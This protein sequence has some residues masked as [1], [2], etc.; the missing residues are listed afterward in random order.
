LEGQ[1]VLIVEDCHLMADTLQD[2]LTAAGAAN[3]TALR[4]IEAL[5]IDMACL[6]VNLGCENSFPLGDK[7]TSVASRSCSSP[8]MTPTCCRRS[9]RSA[10]GEQ[11][12]GLLSNW[13][14]LA[15]RTSVQQKV[16]ASQFPTDPNA[17]NVLFIDRSCFPE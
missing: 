1:R 16:P 15:Q 14:G 8:P 9:L 3:G 2:I 7:L 6:D 13:C 10:L 4:M 11:A 5:E 12:R 17:R